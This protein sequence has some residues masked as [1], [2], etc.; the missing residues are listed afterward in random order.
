MNL[1]IVEPAIPVADG[2]AVER[3]D[4]VLLILALGGGL[5]VRGV[6]GGVGIDEAREEDRVAVGPN[7][8]E[9]APVEIVVTR[10]ASPP[11]ARSRT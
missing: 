4:L 3:A 7:C 11:P 1:P 5:L 10:A 8:G 6:V 9:P 2:E